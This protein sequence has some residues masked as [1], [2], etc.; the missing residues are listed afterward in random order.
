MMEL[1][2]GGVYLAGGETL[3]P[4]GK[5]AAAQL[6]AMGLTIPAEAGEGRTPEEEKKLQNEARK[7]TMAYRILKAHN[8]SG[9]M[10][11][12]QIKFDKMVSHDI[13]F[14]GI[15]QTARASGLEKFPIPYELTN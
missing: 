1:T 15:I 10:Q 8:T 13:T 11:E 2:Q 9:N 14:V 5:E 3:V 7:G 12:L 4:E 6:R